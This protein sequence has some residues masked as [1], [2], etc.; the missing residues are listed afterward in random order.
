[1]L[2]CIIKMLQIR[3]AKLNNARH[4]H[5]RSRNRS[6]VVAACRALDSAVRY[7]HCY[8]SSQLAMLKGQFA[9]Q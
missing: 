3:I 8:F 2:D 7:F 1:M 5:K 4:L 6:G 9:L